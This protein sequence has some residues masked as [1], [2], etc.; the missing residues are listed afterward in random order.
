MKMYTTD[1]LLLL[2]DSSLMSV[3]NESINI[4]MIT[5]VTDKQP[6]LWA[7]KQAP[8]K[9]NGSTITYIFTG[10]HFIATPKTHAT[11]LQEIKDAQ[12]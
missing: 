12:K 11:V 4:D 8:L 1:S 7:N 6:K 3:G 5:A 9:F 10:D 2:P